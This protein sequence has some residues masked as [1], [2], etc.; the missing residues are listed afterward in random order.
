MVALKKIDAEI[1]LIHDRDDEEFSLESIEKLKATYPHLNLI[2][3][4]G[5]GH[6]K[7]LMN[8]KVIASLK[9]YL[10]DQLQMSH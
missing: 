4:Q 8:R 10:T 9:H 6:Q 7:M 5:A 3:T 1:L 2:I